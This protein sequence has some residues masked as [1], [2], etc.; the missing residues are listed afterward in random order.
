MVGY[1]ISKGVDFS[2]NTFSL[3][4]ENG[5]VLAV[6]EVNVPLFPADVG[7]HGVLYDLGPMAIGPFFFEIAIS[8]LRS[9][10]EKR[11][12]SDHNEIRSSQMVLEVEAFQIA[13]V[14]SHVG[15]FGQRFILDAP[16]SV[17]NM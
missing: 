6:E 15:D 14:P 17:A 4:F 7:V 1:R 2:A 9:G 12:E 8:V 3:D 13:I 16:E 5:K 10:F 11:F